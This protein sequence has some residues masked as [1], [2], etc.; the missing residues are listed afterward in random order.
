MVMLDDV[1]PQVAE[2][3][4]RFGAKVGGTATEAP[5]DRRFAVHDAIMNK[6][7][8]SDLGLRPTQLGKFLSA[9]ED[10]YSNPTLIDLD[11]KSP[12]SDPAR[13]LTEAPVW[14]RILTL[15]SA[16]AEPAYRDITLKDLCDE[17]LIQLRFRESH[18]ELDC[19]EYK[20]LTDYGRLPDRAKYQHKRRMAEFM[21]QRWGRPYPGRNLSE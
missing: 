15:G 10:R 5:S 14:K 11:L 8:C 3:L 16:D 19:D 17:I 20:R 1:Y 21:F 4:E 7:I 13:A 2:L 18:N 9:I 12:M 6:L